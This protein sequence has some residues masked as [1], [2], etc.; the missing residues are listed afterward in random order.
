MLFD[1]GPLTYAGRWHEIRDE[2]VLMMDVA[3]HDTGNSEDSRVIH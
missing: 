3:V 2:Q 1:H